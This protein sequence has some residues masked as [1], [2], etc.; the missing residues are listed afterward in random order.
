MDW[1]NKPLLHK[2]MFAI[3]AVAVVL[4][5]VGTLKPDLFPINI[6]FFKM[7]DGKFHKNRNVKSCKREKE[8]HILS[9]FA[10]NC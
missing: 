6:Y 1:K 8:K 3:S 7:Q 4:V 5:A 10:N 9:L 2:I